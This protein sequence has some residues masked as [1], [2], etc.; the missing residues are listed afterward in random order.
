MIPAQVP[1]I[2]LPGLRPEW[3]RLVT[4]PDHGGVSRTWHLLDTGES[5]DQRLTILCVHG[6]PTWSYL[7]RAVL[8]QAP[9]D[10]RVIAVDQLDVVAPLAPGARAVLR[11]ELEVGRLSG[12]GLHRVR[13]VART[14]ADLD[15][16]PDV[17]SEAHVATAL[18]LR[19]SLAA[20]SGGHR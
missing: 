6:N 5:A 17:V 18:R 15:G 3:S 2:G 14:I 8:E 10:I 16:A 7:W 4:A 20:L 19:T 11:R 9:S 1:P 12:R 13:R